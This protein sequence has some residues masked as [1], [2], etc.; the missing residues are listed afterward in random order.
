M[1]GSLNELR[2]AVSDGAASVAK[3]EAAKRG[4]A[5]EDAFSAFVAIMARYFEAQAAEFEKMAAEASENHAVVVAKSAAED[6]AD[7]ITEA[8]MGA[9]SIG[10]DAQE[11][12][13]AESLAVGLSMDVP[14]TEALEWA[15][16]R[17]AEMIKDVDG[18]TMA[19]IRKIIEDALTEGKTLKAVRDEIYAKFAQYSAYR[20]S[21]I[22]VME[23]GNAFEQGKRAQF[24]RYQSQFGRE[25]WKRSYTQGD[26][27]VRETHRQNAEAGWIPANQPFP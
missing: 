19:E 14:S 4:K 21:L 10:L 25:G 5:F 13:I 18:T 26:S 11:A 7:E 1:C 3:A 17:A 12:E 22:A 6:F 2:K 27:N 15:K 8:L 24:S 16:V 9:Y 20:A 23:I